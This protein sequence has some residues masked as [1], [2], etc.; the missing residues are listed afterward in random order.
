MKFDTIY[1]GLDQS[2]H[3]K[4][5]LGPVG[6]G[7][8]PLLWS[9]PNISQL[10]ALTSNERRGKQYARHAHQRGGRGHQEHTTVEF[11]ADPKR[12]KGG[13]VQLA[14]PTPCESHTTPTCAR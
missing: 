11:T 13:Q 4:L 6:Y 10:S 14:V 12:L 7:A 1:D 2:G 9:L 5:A 3:E 8:C